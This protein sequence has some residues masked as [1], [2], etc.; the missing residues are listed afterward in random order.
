MNAVGRQIVANMKK[1]LLS[2]KVERVS[3]RQKKGKVTERV[4]RQGVSATGKGAN[5]LRFEV[6]DD[7]TIQI[8]G[9]AYIMTLVFGRKPTSSGGS[10]T[11]KGNILEWIK[12]KGIQ[13]DGI[14]QESLA[15]LIARKIHQYGSSIYIYN[16]KA[17]IYSNGLFANILDS[18]TLN[19]FSKALAL[20]IEKDLKDQWQQT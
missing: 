19:E 17:N 20:D 13:A 7:G 4:F 15:F 12:A 3:R 2:A 14:K 16:Q 8:Y 11:L 6:T 10:G 9:E 18:K 5:S 1:Q